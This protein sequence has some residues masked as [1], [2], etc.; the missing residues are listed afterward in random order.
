MKVYATDVDGLNEFWSAHRAQ[1]E[2]DMAKTKTTGKGVAALIPEGPTVKE[3]KG[4]RDAR[5]KREKRAAL[6][7]AVALV[8][9]EIAKPPNER[10][11]LDVDEPVP[12]RLTLTGLAKAFED[13]CSEVAIQ[14][15]VLDHALQLRAK[16]RKALDNAADRLANGDA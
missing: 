1:K 15:G 9:A 3:T 6:K 12:V 4:E 8:G 13:A 14:E 2:R 16:A 11:K 7:E 5:R 10:V